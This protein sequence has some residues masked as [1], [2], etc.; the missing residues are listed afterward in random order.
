MP[1]PGEIT[2]NKY[3]LLLLLYNIYY[4]YRVTRNLQDT[5]MGTSVG[6][7]G[8]W[9]LCGPFCALY[10]VLLCNIMFYVPPT[11]S[12]TLR[13]TTPCMYVYRLTHGASNCTRT[14]G[15]RNSFA[16]RVAYSVHLSVIFYSW[17]YK[18]GTVRDFYCH[19]LQY[20]DYGCIVFHKRFK[21]CF[22]N[23]KSFVNQKWFDQN[24]IC[25]G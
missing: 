23:F 17:I 6:R 25:I 16:Q 3:Y 18:P 7:K 14:L 4:M 1:T 19:S 12:F 2:T 22:S 9:F 5:I 10:D 20:M 21:L 24:K 15:F 13:D 8:D 11:A